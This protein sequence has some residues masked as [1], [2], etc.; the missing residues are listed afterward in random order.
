MHGLSASAT[1]LGRDHH[2]PADYLAKPPSAPTPVRAPP[3]PPRQPRFQTAPDAPGPSG[4]ARSQNE[5]VIRGVR[6][7]AC[8]LPVL[9][10]CTPAALGPFLTSVCK[11][12]SLGDA[13]I[14]RAALLSVRCVP[15]HPHPLHTYTLVFIDWKECRA[16]AT[17]AGQ[18][19]CVCGGGG[20]DLVNP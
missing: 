12:D 5:V 7:A 17:V 19:V 16:G 15:P 13:T 11:E 18:G 2:Q 14:Q 3:P 9:M 1:A 10:E 6:M 20:V 8:P 4:S